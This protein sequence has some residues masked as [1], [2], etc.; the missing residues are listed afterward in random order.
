MSDEVVQAKSEIENENTSRVR[1][2]VIYYAFIVT[3]IGIFMALASFAILYLINTVNGVYIASDNL[4]GATR[5]GDILFFGGI[6]ISI[7]GTYM[8]VKYGSKKYNSDATQ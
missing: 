8:S 5:I 2:I 1:S 4:S 3:L 7:V 6:A